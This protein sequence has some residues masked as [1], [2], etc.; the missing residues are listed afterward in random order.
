[1]VPPVLVVVGV[2]RGER[3]RASA[4]SWCGKYVL[5]D[6][7]RVKAKRAGGS[8]K[9]RARVLV[10]KVCGMITRATVSSQ[11]E[12]TGAKCGTKGCSECIFICI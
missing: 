3:V 11:A 9:G 8:A 6:Y 1:M 5:Y 10:C 12:P 4:W 7:V 2:K